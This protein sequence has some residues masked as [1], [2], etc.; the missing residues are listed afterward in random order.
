MAANWAERRGDVVAMRGFWLRG[1]RFCTKDWRM[2]VG[3]AKA[4]LRWVSKSRKS[5]GI[6]G[7]NP[8]GSEEERQQLE[9]E[10]KDADM[11][12]LPTDAETTTGAEGPLVTT[13]AAV[14]VDAFPTFSTTP[15][16]NGAIPKAVFDSAMKDSGNNEVVAQ[17]F[18]DMFAEFAS[19]PSTSQIL[20]HVVD[21]TSSACPASAVS[22]SLQC[23]RPLIGIATDDPSFP[24]ALRAALKQVK[25][26]TAQCANPEQRAALADKLLEWMEPLA[27]DERLVPELRQVL[28]ASLKRIKRDKLA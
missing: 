4:E 14:S 28:S 6:Q 24:D 27:L 8:E 17:Q 5:L 23:R 18:F 19:A 15:A 12:T 13:G 10:E 25:A 2:R 7:M 26:A 16:M 21:T 22:K 20:Q 3:F 11:I 1:C 9:N